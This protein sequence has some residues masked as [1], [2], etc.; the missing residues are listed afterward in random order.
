[1]TGSAQCGAL[2]HVAP[3]PDFASLHPGYIFTMSNSAVSSFPAHSCLRVLSL[4]LPSQLPIPDR[5]DGG[6]PGGGILSP[7]RP[8]TAR[9]HVCEA[10]A[11]PC[12]RDGASRRSTVTVLGPVPALRLRSCL[13]YLSRANLP[14]TVLRPAPGR[15]LPLRLQETLLESAPHERDFGYISRALIVVNYIRS[16]SRSRDRPY[17]IRSG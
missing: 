17:E 13:H 5:G 6:A 12:N 3:T 8:V 15:H 11:I 10:W 4:F 9:H 7:S 14:A 16:Q 1:M 2:V